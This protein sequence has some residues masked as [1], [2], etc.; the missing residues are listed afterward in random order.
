MSSPTGSFGAV[1]LLTLL[2]VAA[3]LYGYRKNLSLIREASM[4]LEEALRPDDAEYTWL[5][6]TVGFSAE[7]RVKGFRSVQAVLRLIPR[8]SL[9]YLP[10]VLLSGRSDTLQLLF[11]LE[12]VQ[13]PVFHILNRKVPERTIAGKEGLGRRFH[14]SDGHDVFYPDSDVSSPLAEE[15][16]RV[17]GE[18]FLHVTLRDDRV[19]Y[20]EMRLTGGRRISET[21]GS[22]KGLL[23]EYN[24]QT[25]RPS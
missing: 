15:L 13:G 25:G 4:Q 12:Q 17:I 24:N 7:Y 18:E 16:G 14:L 11:R 3:Y 8:Q 21:V 9:L 20:A 10:V 23:L 19:F 6:G 2:L 22:L 5:G 1:L